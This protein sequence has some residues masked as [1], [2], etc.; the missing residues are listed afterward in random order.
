MRVEFNHECM[1]DF[2]LK[3]QLLLKLIS[4]EFTIPSSVFIIY[5]IP[6]QAC[7][8]EGKFDDKGEWD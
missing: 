7:Y 4:I 6:F 5:I 2:N 1:D 3:T 8:E